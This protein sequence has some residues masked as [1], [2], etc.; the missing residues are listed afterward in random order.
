M[1][2]I[3][4]LA[5]VAPRTDG[6]LPDGSRVSDTGRVQM[7]NA[8]KDKHHNVDVSV[9]YQQGTKSAVE[10]VTQAVAY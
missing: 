8:S 6:A 5:V 3:Q 10:R 9:F 2:L 4:P 7:T 1:R